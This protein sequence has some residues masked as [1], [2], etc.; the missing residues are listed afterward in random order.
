[1]ANH[2]FLIVG[3]KLAISLF[4]FN[5]IGTIFV[6]FKPAFVFCLELI[7]GMVFALVRS[8]SSWRGKSFATIRH[9]AGEIF[10][11]YAQ[12]NM[13]IQLMNGKLFFFVIYDRYFTCSTGTF[14]GQCGHCSFGISSPKNKI[15]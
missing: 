3:A 9:I 15:I 2:T 6:I 10:A 8:D 13:V 12:C 14:F 7:S 5:C 11:D 1:M 4:Y